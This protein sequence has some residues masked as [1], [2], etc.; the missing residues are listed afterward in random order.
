[1]N[2]AN[3]NFKLW[4][5]VLFECFW[6][7]NCHL[8]LVWVCAC[9]AATSITGF[10]YYS[11]SFYGLVASTYNIHL[12]TYYL[13]LNTWFFKCIIVFILIFIFLLFSWNVYGKWLLSLLLNGKV[14]KVWSMFW[15]IKPFEQSP[16]ALWNTA[17]NLRFMILQY[18]T[19]MYVYHNMF[20]ISVSRIS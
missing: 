4:A 2:F 10:L 5:T 15:F 7:A 11:I 3:F 20:D 13:S 14:N 19:W 17:G 18:V 12:C 6:M 8:N 1:M 9:V 16:V